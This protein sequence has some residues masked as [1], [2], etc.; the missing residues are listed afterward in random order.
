MDQEQLNK[1]ILTFVA[2]APD[3]SLISPAKIISWPEKMTGEYCVYQEEAQHR[4]FSITVTKRE[5][6]YHLHLNYFLWRAKNS[7]ENESTQIP[8]G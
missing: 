1:R 2:P 5:G 7:G 8:K 4:L 6:E 3:T